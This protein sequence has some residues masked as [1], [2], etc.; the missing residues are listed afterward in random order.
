MSAANNIRTQVS[1]ALNNGAKN[2]IDGSKFKLDNSE[3][4]Y[5]SPSALINVDHSNNDTLSLLLVLLFRALRN[6]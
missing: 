3:N 2:I 6:A 5:V 1:K 4:C